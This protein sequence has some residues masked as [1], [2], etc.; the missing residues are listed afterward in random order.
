MRTKNLTPNKNRRK[1]NYDNYDNYTNLSNR[2]KSR[3]LTNNLSNRPKSRNLPNILSNR[4]KSRNLS[5][6]DNYVSNRQNNINPIFFS[7]DDDNNAELDILK[8]RIKDLESKKDEDCHKQLA[9]CNKKLKKCGEDLEKIKNEYGTKIIELNSAINDNNI[10]DGKILNL[11]EQLK[12]LN[13]DYQNQISEINKMFDKQKATT[14]TTNVLKEGSLNVQI[15]LLETQISQLT[16]EVENE[17]NKIT[18]LENTVN[19]LES[20]INISNTEINRLTEENITL[21]S[22]ISETENQKKELLISRDILILDKK[23]L[24][25]QIENNVVN[26]SEE[27]Q[28]L[29]NVENELNSFHKLERLENKNQKEKLQ[30]E[31]KALENQIEEL[32]TEKT[33]LEKQLESLS[34]NLALLDTNIL[35]KDTKLA[36][37]NKEITLL[38]EGISKIQKEYDILNQAKEEVDDMITQCK[39]TENI[40]SE[41]NEKNKLENLKRKDINKQ[42]SEENINLGQL[43]D[44]FVSQIDNTAQNLNTIFA[45]LIKIKIDDIQIPSGLKTINTTEFNKTAKTDILNGF[46][47]I[48]IAITK[49]KEIIIKN[50]LEKQAMKDDYLKQIEQNKKEFES[51]KIILEDNIKFFENEI[52]NNKKENDKLLSTNT[53]LKE[54]IE[55][56]KSSNNSLL[57]ELS[58]LKEQFE[59]LKRANKL[60]ADQLSQS[61]IEVNK[62][63]DDIDQMSKELNELITKTKSTIAGK[64]EKIEKLSTEINN[65][66]KLLEIIAE[67]QSVNSSKI[68]NLIKGDGRKNRKKK[69]KRKSGKKRNK[70]M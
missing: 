53:E 17:K 21:K 20:R 62:Y 56:L 7:F 46:E 44:K 45:E 70:K 50:Q 64:D 6:Y 52:E 65:I 4:P 40:L 16:I 11:T 55:T 51:V 63:K 2:P 9:E 15:K 30:I 1:L 43:N 48:N 60:L 27:I 13:K 14:F 42:L 58:E 34:E 69:Y 35:E 37:N 26:T 59:K 33:A 57:S 68:E 38:S 32:K 25:K 8:K 47:S 23:Q 5:D 36:E 31:K 19:N 54:Q 24:Q 49:L 12:V 29:K 61:K 22:K 66:Q 10:K 67:S 41:I 39:Q 28:R 3:N 18:N